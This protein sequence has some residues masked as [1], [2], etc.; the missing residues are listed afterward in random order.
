MTDSLVIL[1]TGGSAYDVLD[2]VEAINAQRPMWRVG[3][4][5][6]D[7]LPIGDRH[8]GFDI[9]GRLSDACRLSGHRFINVIGSDRSYRRRP[10]IIAGTGLRPEQF[11]TLVHPAASVS[12]RARIGRGTYV[13]YGVSVGGGVTLGDH[14]SLSP[15]AI[16]GHDA[17]IEDYALVAPGAV[18]SGFV[19]L[20]TAA[21][22]GARAVI[23]QHLRVGEQALVGM[24]AV[25][26]REVAAGETVVGN[27][28]R[29]LPRGARTNGVPVLERRCQPG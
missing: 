16:V 22:V 2:I 9:L 5:L 12:P 14:V 1:G 27:P 15:S 4:F 26:V 7:A 17:V 23:R 11:A 24:G 3:G 6:D 20:A 8:L 28:A 18:L 25:V 13:S 29:V 21:Y 19:H 10:E